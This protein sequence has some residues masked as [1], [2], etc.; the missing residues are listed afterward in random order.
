MGRVVFKYK[1][2]GVE[3]WGGGVFTDEGRRPVSGTKGRVVFPVGS[4]I[5]VNTLYFERKCLNTWNS[6]KLTVII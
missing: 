3:V 1:G 5:L 6:K 4:P 2:N